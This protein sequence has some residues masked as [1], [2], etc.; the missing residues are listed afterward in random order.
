MAYSYKK[1]PMYDNRI[2]EYA[3]HKLRYAPLLY[4]L[5]SVWA[6]SNQQVFRDLVI[7]ITTINFYPYSGHYVSQWITQLTPATIWLVVAVVV[8]LNLLYSKIGFNLRGCFKK[9]PYAEIDDE[10]FVPPAEENEINYF[11]RLKHTDHLAWF[12]EEYYTKARYQIHRLDQDNYEA[13][14]VQE[15]KN[16]T[17]PKDSQPLKRIWDH[18][19]YDPL[20]SIDSAVQYLYIPFS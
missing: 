7:P 9:D 3:L 18:P 16:S 2:T 12:K 4:A 11:N 6:F 15:S 20:W 8:I 14:E 1:P 13:L 10:Q 19:N 17:S 5:V